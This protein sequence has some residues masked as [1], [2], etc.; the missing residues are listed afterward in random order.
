MAITK[1]KK[2]SF[3]AF[4]VYGNFEDA[5]SLGETIELASSTVTCVD[6]N[7][8]D[9]TSDCIESSSLQVQ[10]SKLVAQC[11]NGEEALSPYLITFRIITTDNNKYEVDLKMI[12]K[13]V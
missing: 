9:V 11:K 3:E 7:G 10:D 1:F 4:P 8:D 2:Q 13:E 6:V 12:V 5:L